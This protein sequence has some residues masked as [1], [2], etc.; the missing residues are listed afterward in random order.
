MVEFAQCYGTSELVVI[1]DLTSKRPLAI[2]TNSKY[3][4]G[5]QYLFI[6]LPFTSLYLMVRPNDETLNEDESNPSTDYLIKFRWNAVLQIRNI[7]FFFQKDSKVDFVKHLDLNE[8]L[9]SW[10]KIYFSTLAGS[11]MIADA[12][13]NVIVANDTR[14]KLDSICTMRPNNPYAEKFIFT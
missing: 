13:Y 2:E 14:L 7:D 12:T 6:A 1:D 4:Y 11:I 3:E 5:R 8:V 10:S 9:I